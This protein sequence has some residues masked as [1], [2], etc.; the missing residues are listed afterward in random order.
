MVLLTDGVFYFHWPDNQSVTEW[1]FEI[2]PA[3][4]IILTKLTDYKE[5]QDVYHGKTPE[6]VA[7][8][9]KITY[10]RDDRPPIIQFKEK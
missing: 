4:I 1:V 5:W 6:G 8:Y 9:I 3:I 7:V 10:S 2:I